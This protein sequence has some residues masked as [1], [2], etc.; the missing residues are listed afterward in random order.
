MQGASS[1]IATIESVQGLGSIGLILEL[2]VQVA[3][4]VVPKVVADVHFFYETKTGEFLKHFRVE[5]VEFALHFVG[6]WSSNFWICNELRHRVHVH[7]RYQKSLAKDWSV[8][9]A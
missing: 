4:Q 1:V 5:I 8:V 2:D 7:M 6:V 9:K 3:Y